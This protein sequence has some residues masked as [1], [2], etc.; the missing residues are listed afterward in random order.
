MLLSDIPAA[1]LVLYF[2]WHIMPSVLFFAPDFI[3]FFLFFI[4][5]LIHDV[6]FPAMFLDKHVAFMLFL[7]CNTLF[8]LTKFK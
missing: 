7:N 4:K 3:A 2:A 1:S 5:Q 6:H 8:I